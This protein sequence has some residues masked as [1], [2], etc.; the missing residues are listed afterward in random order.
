MAVSPARWTA[1]HKPA[2][3]TRATATKAAAGAGIRNLLR[4]MAVFLVA[5]T[6]A[7]AAIQVNVYVIDGASGGTTYLW[8]AV[9]ALQAVA[10]DRCAFV[11]SG[12]EID[13]TANTA[14]TLEFDLAGGAN[15]FESVAM[16]GTTVV[17]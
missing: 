1:V 4:S 3:N 12:L 14:L 9:F 5:G 16:M 7:P 8:V 10:G 15:T 11:Q 6:T 13:G 17:E 2:V